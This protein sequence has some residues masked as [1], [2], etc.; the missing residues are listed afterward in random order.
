MDVLAETLLFLL[1]TFG[2]VPDDEEWDYFF[3]HTSRVMLPILSLGLLYAERLD[4]AQLLDWRTISIEWCERLG[5]VFWFGVIIS[6]IMSLIY[7]L[8]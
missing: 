1:Q 8:N 3:Y 4:N 7:W 5:K 2:I 6:L